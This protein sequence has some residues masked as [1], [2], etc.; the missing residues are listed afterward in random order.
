MDYCIWTNG[1][2]DESDLVVFERMVTM[3]TTSILSLKKWWLR[4]EQLF[5]L[6]ECWQWR[7]LPFCFT[8]WC[9]DW[10]N[11]FMFERM[12]TVMREPF[13]VWKKK[14]D[15]REEPFCVSSIW[16]LTLSVQVYAFGLIMLWKISEPVWHLHTNISTCTIRTIKEWWNNNNR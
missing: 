8:E 4:Q 12:M 6:K 16:L 2:C 10:S 7:E 9:R 11:Q 3:W 1:D 13:C 14:D 5:C 15:R